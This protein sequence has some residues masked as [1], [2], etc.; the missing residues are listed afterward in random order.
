M[1]VG[2]DQELQVRGGGRGFVLAGGGETLINR[3]LI[4]AQDDETVGRR[5]VR[6][7]EAE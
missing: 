7:E 5:G 3:E 1:G 6:E 2:A 4:R